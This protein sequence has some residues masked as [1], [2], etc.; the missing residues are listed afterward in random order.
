MASIT[1]MAEQLG[2]AIASSPQAANLRAARKELNAQ[3]DVKRLLEDYR[4]QAEKIGHLEE[5][6]KPVEPED[7]RQ[8]ED[9]H[10][11]LVA[12]DVFKKFTAAQVEYIDLM[13]KVNQSMAKAL[14]EVDQ[15]LRA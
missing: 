5:E 7:K 9:L 1:E 13:R 10:G 14:A 8:L 4:K 2:K 15:E 11:K 6:Q 3:P 12:S